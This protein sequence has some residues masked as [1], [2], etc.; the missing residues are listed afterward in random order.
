MGLFGTI[1]NALSKG[2]NWL[3]GKIR[4]IG[5]FGGKVARRIGEFAPQIGSSIGGLIGDNPVGNMIKGIGQKVGDFASGAGSAIAKSVGDI[6]T[7]ISGIGN[8]LSSK[9]TN[10]G[11]KGA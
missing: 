3:G 2:A 10:N 9:N 5:D 8:A 11:Q 6:G 4:T 7:S 1:G